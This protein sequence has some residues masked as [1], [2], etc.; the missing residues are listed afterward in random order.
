MAGAAE[1]SRRQALSRAAE[2]V[3]RS[4]PPAAAGSALRIGGKAYVFGAG[5]TAA[6]LTA[7]QAASTAAAASLFED[8]GRAQAERALAAASSVG[9]DPRSLS[10]RVGGDSSPRWAGD[11]L[12]AHGTVGRVFSPRPQELRGAAAV[13]GGSEDDAESGGLGRGG[14]GGS[15]GA[16]AVPLPF[17]SRVALL[18]AERRDRGGVQTTVFNFRDARSGR[19]AQQAEQ[20]LGGEGAGV[21]DLSRHPAEFTHTDPR[22]APKVF[23]APLPDATTAIVAEVRQ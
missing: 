3:R 12:E 18:D 2:A 6:A 11:D 10:D 5:V 16:G 13:N 8:Q 22:Y 1:G 4:G 23:A 14:A 17:P 15:G 20:L 21:R 9:P 19:A 7:S